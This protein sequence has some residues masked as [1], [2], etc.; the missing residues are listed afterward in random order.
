MVGRHYRLGICRKLEIKAQKI[1]PTEVLCR[2]NKAKAYKECLKYPDNKIL[3]NGTVQI[4]F[5]LY[6]YSFI[7]DMY[8]KNTF[9]RLTYSKD[10]MTMLILIACMFLA[11]NCIKVTDW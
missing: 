9:F 10:N 5:Q 3:M 4:C 11:I 1:K 7:C 2:I 6:S 8:I